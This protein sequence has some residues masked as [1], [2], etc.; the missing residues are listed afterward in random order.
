MANVL[1]KKDDIKYR[2]LLELQEISTLLGCENLDEFEAHITDKWGE[3]AGEVGPFY[4]E[5]KL[6]AMIRT[7]F[8]M[9]HVES[10]INGLP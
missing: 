1:S 10:M 2:G 3:C 8:D 9:A 6:I 4:Q 5:L 7:D